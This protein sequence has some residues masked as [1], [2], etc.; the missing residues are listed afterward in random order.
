MT[1]PLTYN[2]YVVQVA[3]MAVYQT[4]TIDNIAQMAEP[5]ANSIIPQMLNYA[6]L[7]IQRD[8]DLL[9]LL[10]SNDYALAAGNN[11]LSIPVAD[12]V[13]VQTL[14]VNVDGQLSPLLPVS[15]EYIQAVWPSSATQ[16][17]PR[18]FAMIG[19]DSATYGNTSTNIM[20]GPPPDGA[21]PVSIFGTQR[22]GSLNDFAN[23]TDAGSGTTFIS[24]WL[25][26]L[27]LQ[28]S[29]IFVAEF[30]RNFGRVSDDP[31]MAM[32][33]EAQYQA[34]LQG[35]ASEEAR[36]RFAGGAWS[37]MGPTPAATPTR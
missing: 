37:S 16:A 18:V 31:Q 8:L 30:Q 9:P 13:T 32:T 7:R 34:L 20:V 21:Y 10:T 25:P 2:Q 33:Y 19:G 24:Y 6:E 22:M 11:L 36:K 4:T 29:L 28:A 26:D 5:T 15:K 35:A 23:P 3:A 14:S 1:N 12:F 17:P 27:L